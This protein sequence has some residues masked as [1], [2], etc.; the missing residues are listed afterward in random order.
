MRGL[1][2]AGQAGVTVVELIVALGISGIFLSTVHGFYLLHQRVFMREI[3]R[4]DV[5]QDCRLALDFIVREL[6]L[7]GAR[8]VQNADC[9]G[10][11]RLPAAEEARVTLQYDFRGA[12]FG[13]APDGCPDDP[14]ER[15][16]YLYDSDREM[17]R[18][19]SGGG[20]PQ[21]FISGVPSGGFTL[22]YFN[23]DGTELVPGLDAAERADIRLVEVSVQTTRVRPGAAGQAVLAELRSAVFLP[24]PAR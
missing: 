23:R 9:D 1:Q 8:P 24:N 2:P 11:E 20:S 5:Q 7:S 15:I 17:I 6:R 3:A 19:A 13:S 22:R 12:R 14:S 4:L 21:P 10:F 16:T 18:R